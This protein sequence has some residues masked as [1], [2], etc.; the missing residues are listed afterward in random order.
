MVFFMV[1]L[2]DF[3]LGD[4]LLDLLIC[5]LVIFLLLIF[6]VVF[7]CFF[8]CWMFVCVFMRFDVVWE[9]V[10]EVMYVYGGMFLG[11]CWN[12]EFLFNFFFDSWVWV[13]L[14]F[15]GIIVFLLLF[16]FFGFM[17]L[18]LREWEWDGEGERDVI[19]VWSLLFL[20]RRFLSFCF[21]FCVVLMMF[22]G[23][24]VCGVWSD[25]YFILFYCV[26]VFL[27]FLFVCGFECGLGLRKRMKSLWFYLFWSRVVLSLCLCFYF[28]FVIFGKIVFFEGFYW[29]FVFIWICVCNIFKVC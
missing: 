4:F 8:F 15:L 23:G 17:E 6:F 5:I 11:E 27:V 26:F 1:F 24:E 12:Y 14:F 2:C 7:F 20:L 25:V 3:V 9:E 19:C 10:S 21:F 28:G 18:C 29:F 22:S 16:F 13:F